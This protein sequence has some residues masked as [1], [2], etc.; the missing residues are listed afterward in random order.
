MQ[1]DFSR[2]PDR[3]GTGSLKWEKYRDKDILPMW[4]AD[5]DFTSPPPVIEAL[6]EVSSRGL[7]GYTVP[8]SL[9]TEA[10]VAYMSRRYQWQIQPEWIVWMPGLVPALNTAARAYGADD[11]AVL[12]FTPVY[13][14]FLTAPGFQGKRVQKVPLV[15][16]GNRWTIDLE[17]AAAAVTKS[18]RMLYLCNP[19][20]PV[21]RVFDRQEL[22]ALYGFCLQN[23]LLIISDEIHCDLILDENCQH[24]VTAAWSPEIAARTITLMAPSKTYNIPGL[25]CSFVIISDAQLRQ[26]F[27]RASRGMITEI[28][29][30]GY[31]GCRAALNEGEEWRQALLQTLRENYRLVYDTFCR[32]MPDLGMLPMEA[33]YL[34][35]LNANPLGLSNPVAHFEEFG[36]GLSDGTPFG[37]PGWLRLNFGCPSHQLRL[38]LER[39]LAGYR[40]AKSI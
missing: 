35:W 34:A 8:T 36:I 12:T 25:S 33:T 7:F 23:N 39:L 2:L 22:S 16:D 26:Q 14:P 38:G 17:A 9:D 31:A 6:K 27:Q 30:F 18:T 20:N 28:N 1:T 3:R 37:F 4:V 19:H 10:V 32:E 11:E 24:Q 13:P 15:I 5:M 21:G 40:A 29:I